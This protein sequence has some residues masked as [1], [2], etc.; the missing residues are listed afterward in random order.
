M[1]IP[2]ELDKGYYHVLGQLHKLVEVLSAEVG[3]RPGG[4]GLASPGAIDPVTKTLKG[5]GWQ[6]LDGKPLLSDLQ[7]Y[8]GVPI[9]SASRAS[10]FTLA[11]TRL[12][13]IPAS[14]P[15]AKVTMGLHLDHEV[16][17]GIVINGQILR[18]KQGIAGSWGHNY[19]DDSG[20]KCF[21]GKYGCVQTMLSTSSL[22]QFYE[23]QS[24]QTLSIAEIAQAAEEG[25]DE[26]AAKTAERLVYNFAKAVGPVINLLDPD[27]IIIGGVVGSLLP[28]ATQAPELIKRFVFNSR[29]DTPLLSSQLNSQAVAIGAAM[30]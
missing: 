27:A 28:V 5:S 13:S 8:L 17:A 12:G 14:M 10:C 29:L 19:L 24:S 11:E 23:S 22:E 16:T 9:K 6:H 7:T 20:G 18:G 1:R 3:V 4:I 15:E 26:A 2:T 21:C 30:L 25:R